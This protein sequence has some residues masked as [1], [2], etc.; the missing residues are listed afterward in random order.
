MA[1]ISTESNSPPT[2]YTPTY[3]H[4]LSIND[5]EDDPADNLP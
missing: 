5:Y 4:I 2:P 3:S 1:S